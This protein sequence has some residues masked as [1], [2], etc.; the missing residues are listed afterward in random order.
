[1]EDQVGLAFH[2]GLSLVDD[3]QVLSVV[4]VDQLRCGTHLQRGASDDQAVGAA[5]QVNGALIGF[6]REEF[7]VEGDIGADQFAAGGTGRDLFS[8]LEDEIFIVL[9]ATGDAVVCAD[10]PVDLIDIFAAGF[11]VQAVNILRDHSLQ[12]ACSLKFRQFIVGGIGFCPAGIQVFSIVGKE[13]FR[14]FVKA[15][16][17]QQILRFLFGEALLSLSVEAVF[18]A[19]IRDAALRRYPGAAQKSHMA[20]TSQNL[21]QGIEFLFMRHAVEVIVLFLFR[22]EFGSHLSLCCLLFSGQDGLENVRNINGSHM[23]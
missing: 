21:P 22:A 15:V 23:L 16:I 13:D 20:A 2:P 19:E 18:T 10:G 1:M 7:P 8:A 5:D 4:D 11:L 14:L 12:Y 6:F 3:D 9:P 17:A